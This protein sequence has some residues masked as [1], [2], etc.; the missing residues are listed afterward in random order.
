MPEFDP[1]V[2][3]RT[4]ARIVGPYLIA[5]AAM[6]LA[7]HDQLGALLSAYMQDDVLVLATGAF[8]LMAGLA[9]VAAHHHW[10]GPSAIVIFAHWRHRNAEGRMADDRAKLWLGDDGARRSQSQP[11]PDYRRHRVSGRMLA[12]F[13][14]LAARALNRPHVRDEARSV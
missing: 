8:T 14:R 10:T 12:E 2:R 1:V 9:I 11:P 5:V 7:R 3:T 13:R 4:L 6:V